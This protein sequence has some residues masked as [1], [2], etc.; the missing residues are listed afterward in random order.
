MEDFTVMATF[1]LYR[2]AEAGKGRCPV[3]GGKIKKTLLL[4]DLN[5]NTLSYQGLR[6]KATPKVVEF[7][8]TLI[9]AYPKPVSQVALMEALYGIDAER[10]SFGLLKQYA[11]HINVMLMPVSLRVYNVIN[12]SFRL[13]AIE[14]EE[15]DGRRN[16]R[17]N[18]A[19]RRLSRA[20]NSSSHVR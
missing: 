18:D 1:R 8:H 10:K 20:G 3:C 19:H 2:S 4:A 6:W 12:R 15:K 17:P 5:T 11:W 16:V 13:G 9:E 14:E 7:L